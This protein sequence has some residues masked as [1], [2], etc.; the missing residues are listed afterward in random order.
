MS[1]E[2]DKKRPK[3]SVQKRQE[4]QNQQKPIEVSATGKY[5]RLSPRKARCVINAIRG[6]TVAEALQILQMSPKKAARL[7]EKVLQS[8]IAN[9]ENNAKLDVSSLY[10][11][12]CVVN[13]GPRLKRIWYRGRGR[14]DI[15]QKRM[16]HI[17]VKLK[18]IETKA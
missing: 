9:A 8:A 17:T 11:S 7:V 18:P 5:L 2:T 14:A 10:I 3:R 12:H 16:C 15:I 13:D 1:N 6:K 4:E